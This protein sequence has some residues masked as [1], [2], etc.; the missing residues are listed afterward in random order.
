MAARLVSP[1]LF[2]SALKKGDPFADGTTKGLGTI[3]TSTIREDHQKTRTVL[4]I[5]CG[6]A[7]L[8]VPGGAHVHGPGPDGRRRPRRTSCRPLH[9]VIRGG[10]SDWF[11]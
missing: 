6:P 5:A 8:E 10:S 11:V 9:M 4:G 1:P 2:L 7:E 3:M